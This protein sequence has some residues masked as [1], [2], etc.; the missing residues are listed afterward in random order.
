MTNEDF[1]AARKALLELQG[2]A[3]QEQQ[4]G[5]ALTLHRWL[6]ELETQRWLHTKSEVKT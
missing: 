5:L 4:H 1:Q 3:L 6:D 2:R